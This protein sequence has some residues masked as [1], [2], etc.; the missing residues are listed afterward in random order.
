MRKRC[1]KLCR[2][3]ERMAELQSPHIAEAGAVGSKRRGR[4]VAGG[5]K[6]LPWRNLRNR[7]GPV[8]V[9][10]P[11]GL[12]RIHDISMRVLET[13]GLEFLN[14]RALALLRQHGAN[15]DEATGRVRFDRGLI[16][17]YLAKAPS[18]FTLHARNPARNVVMGGDQLAFCS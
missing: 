3:Q 9:I 14:P 10:D 11:E 15:V 13:E 6:Q 12:E 16:A 4:R 8:E 2:E 7:Y 1:Y 17:D 5:F 18:S